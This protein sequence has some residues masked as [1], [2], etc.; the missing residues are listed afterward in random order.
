MVGIPSFEIP[1]WQHTCA[2]SKKLPYKFIKFIFLCDFKSLDHELVIFRMF[3]MFI[4]F[5]VVST[6]YNKSCFGNSGIRDPSAPLGISA[7]DSHPS[8]RNTGACWGPRGSR[9][10]HARKAPQVHFDVSLTQHSSCEW[11]IDR[12]IR[13]Q[14]AA[15]QT[16]CIGREVIH[17]VVGCHVM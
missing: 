13:T 5:I 6:S 3:I 9:H 16:S 7:A 2:T 17:A 15:C 14:R 10:T 12:L 4:K 1:I 11:T 8:N